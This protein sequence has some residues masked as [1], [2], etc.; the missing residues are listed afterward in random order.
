MKEI[1][2]HK[3]K[4]RAPKI[5]EMP[6]PPEVAGLPVIKAEPWF[7]IHPDV[8][9]GMLEGPA[10][11]RQNNLYICVGGPKGNFSKILRITPEKEVTTILDS[12]TAVPTGIA[13]HKN[14]RLFAASMSGELL[15]MNPDGSGLTALRQHYEGKMLALNDLVFDKNGNL[16]FTDFSGSVN[17]PVGGVY[18]L[19]ASD[20]YAT[21]HQIAGKLAGPNG[22][23][24]SPSGDTLWIGETIRNAVIRIDLLPDGLAP[25]PIDGITWPFYSTGGPAG[26]DSNK[27]DSAGNL[28]GATETGGN[29]GVG[30]IYRL[31][32]AGDFRVLY[33]FPGRGF[34]GYEGFPNAGVVLDS[35]GNI[36]GT[37]PYGGVE[38][39]IYK[40][41]AAGQETTLYNFQGAPGGTKPIAG[42]TLDSAGRLYGATQGGGAVN[43]GV[44][45]RVDSA[46]HETAI[47]SF[48]GGADGASP[49]STP[50][51]DSQGNVYG[52][53][54]GGGSA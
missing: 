7:L 34:D 22:I 31:D 49:E 46:G 14:G 36:Y 37:T 19:D 15:I 12:P 44:V 18:R 5:D 21:L 10:F 33:Q 9:E 39:M 35:E 20:N 52:T 43:W 38:G 28:Y 40:L 42:V 41:D 24:L 16:Y 32:A 54:L 29:A 2:I 11:D 25:R 48:T 8:K 26:P 53:A 50:V 47:Y 1:R 4:N 6:L 51:V 27:V 3:T 45:Y 17:N 13:V 23:S 30:V